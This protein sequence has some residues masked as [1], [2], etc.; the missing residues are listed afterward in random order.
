MNTKKAHLQ[1]ISNSQEL[2]NI[3]KNFGMNLHKMLNPFFKAITSNQ[4]DWQMVILKLES[5]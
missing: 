1:M 2:R 4:M 5:I 3:H